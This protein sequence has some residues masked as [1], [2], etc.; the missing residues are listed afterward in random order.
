[1][2]DDAP[3]SGLGALLGSA[4]IGRVAVLLA[5]V[6][7]ATVLWPDLAFAHDC[8]GPQDCEQ[9]AGY[10]AVVSVVGAVS[11]VVA[12]ILGST[13]AGT[14]AGVVA[15]T[16]P[17]VS[18]SAAGGTQPPSGANGG[19]FKELPPGSQGW[20]VTDVDGKAHIF[21]TEE[22]AKRYW[23]HL[24][25]KRDEEIRQENVRQ[26]ENDYHNA[27]EQVEFIN[28][29][30]RGLKAAGK[31]ASTQI[32]E[33]E[34]W[35]RERDRLR[36]EVGKM[37]GA[38]DYQ[39]RE[40]GSW[41]FGEHDDLIRKANEIKDNQKKLEAIHR[42]ED[43]IDRMRDKKMVGGDEKLT[44]RIEDRLR[45]LSE[46]TVSK[47]GKP[48][49]WDDI[50]RMRD[51][52]RKDMS[53]TAA[54]Q[55]AADAD[56]VRDGAASTA[57]EVFTGKNAD[58]ETSYKSMVLRGLVG[59]A[60]GG[61]SEIGMEVM[62]K[63]Y[64]IHDDVMAGKSGLEAYRNAVTR[65]LVDEG[66]SRITGKVVE[67]GGQGAGWV[68]DKTLKG[69]A[70]D[71]WVRDGARS[72][73]TIL[74][75]DVKD[76]LRGSSRDTAEDF[77]RRMA[78][79]VRSNAANEGRGFDQRQADYD[80]GRQ[81]GAE[82]VDD[83]QQ[84]LENRRANPG[85]EADA[86]V[87]DAV[88]AVQQDKHAMHQLNG[89]SQNK[90]PNDTIRGFN[91]ELG[92][93]YERAHQSARERVAQEYGVHVDDVQVVKPTNK[94]GTGSVDVSDPRGFARKPVGAV[95]TDGRTFS[96]RAPETPVT[97]R[98]D[99][100]SF[101]Q[102]VGYRVRQQ[103]VV[104]P[105]TGQVHSG[106]VDVP[107]GDV[108][109][110][111]NEEFYKSRHGGE[112]PQRVNPETGRMEVDRNAVDHYA[113]R[114]DQAST[115]RLH[116]E[117]YGTGDRDLKTATDPRARG[118]D[119]SDVEQVGKASEHKNYEWQNKAAETR[120]EAR[121]FSARAD[122]ARAEGRLDEASALDR[123][124]S[125]AHQRAESQIEEGYRQTTKQFRNQLQSRVDEIN[126]QAGRNVA[127]VPQRLQ[128]AVDV[129]NDRNLSPVE[130][131]RRLGAMGYTPD[132]VAQQ[133]SSN[134][135]ALQK[136]KPSAGVDWSGAASE[137]LKAASK[138]GD[139]P[140]GLP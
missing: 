55:E 129:M 89:L 91:E 118:R 49:S 128:R 46:N 73:S 36:G 78:H 58:G 11:A 30:I 88:D 48:P 63:M 76:V 109:R 47:D 131:E 23:Q 74:Q 20:S 84:A 83:L 130:I 50:D 100:A 13:F 51:L 26:T 15:G 81:R 7:G 80:A 70:V 126:R 35:A 34:R 61:Q 98:A 18:T 37:G 103:N 95:E 137:G 64:G 31:D 121:E 42:L 53:A 16:V 40:R 17:P 6:A 101:D 21:E 87:R 9:T 29:V 77:E 5:I 93:S 1:M 3:L 116:T 45:K 24:S 113:D 97:G 52:V 96:Q 106:H 79:G 43:A 120:Q 125:E 110:I 92:T 112:L 108:K 28:S 67:T 56:W 57:R 132:K 19:G 8:S 12:G 44:D 136:F 85:A 14:A 135:E 54:K 39:P 119:F 25:D 60:T 65:V 71:T 122:A 62:E 117:S 104:D 68:Y 72:A 124:A 123:R 139:G 69:S 2:R 94:P 66:V 102:D 90:A 4:T 111:Y 140:I 27:A 41:T 32:A 10:N 38:T 22:E 105:R 33:A 133:L 114:M 127:E 86:R 59:A 99:G 107:S 82:K 115:D 134:L 138:T 75:K